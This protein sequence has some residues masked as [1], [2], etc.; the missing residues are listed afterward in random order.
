MLALAHT[1][2]ARLIVGLTAMSLLVGWAPAGAQGSAAPP[3]KTAT[4]ESPQPAVADGTLKA[5]ETDQAP[6]NKLVATVLGEEVRTSDVGE[7]QDIVL[8][9]LFDRYAEEQGITVTNAETDAYVDRLRRGMQ[10]EGLTAEDNLTPEETAEVEQM[11]R[12]MARSM[13]RQWKANRALYRQYGG[14]IIYQ[15]FGPEPLDAY[16]HYL[17]ERQVAGD[18][19]IHEKAFEDVFWRYFTDDTVHD[20]FQPGSEEEAQ[21]FATLPWEPKA[22]GK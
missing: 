18:F 10:A 20:F 21:V 22:G 1:M 4:A 11:R 15:Q 8:T 5:Q 19:T 16:R 7:M 3:V 9:R 13:I 17:E 14:R 2:N 6:N 12:N